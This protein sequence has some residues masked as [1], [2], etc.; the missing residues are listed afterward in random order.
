[1]SLEAAIAYALE[2]PDASGAAPRVTPNSGD[3]YPSIG[4]S[5]QFNA[6]DTRRRC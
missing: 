5:A 3:E 4:T 1:L 2:E 6:R